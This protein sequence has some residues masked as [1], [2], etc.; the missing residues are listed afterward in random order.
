M[1]AQGPKVTLNTPGSQVATPP[2]MV[3][4][5]N[6]AEI[7]TDALGRALAVRQPSA[8]EKLRLYKALGSDL[9]R[10][11]AYIGMA[12]VAISV[13]AINGELTEP[14]LT[15]RAVEMLVSQLD[16][17]GINA[18]AVHLASLVDQTETIAAAKN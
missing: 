15:E 13:R 2:A 1:D 5:Q 17:A 8:L 6:G 3:A 16:D 7:V 9:S 18:V 10:N 4:V 11:H 14:P 12:V